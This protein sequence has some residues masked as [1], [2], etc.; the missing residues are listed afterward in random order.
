MNLKSLQI[1][2]T[3]MKKGSLAKAADQHCLSESAASRQISQLEAQV[4]FK[5]FSREKRNL[6]PTPKGYKFY[7]EI[8]RILYGLN[9][10]PDIVK[11]ITL[12]DRN[13]LRVVGIPR[14]VRNIMS[15]AVARMCAEHKDIHVHIDVQAMR[16][17]E[18]WVAGYQFNLGLGRVP[19][20]HPSIV[21]KT[22]CSLPTVAVL[23]YGHP[24]SNRSEI[25]LADLD[26]L[27]LVSL[28]KDTFLAKNIVSLY[29]SQGMVYNP[30]IEVASSFHAC[31]IVASGYGFTIGDPLAAHSLGDNAVSIV[32][33]TTDFKFDFAFFEPVDADLSDS[34]ILFQKYILE[35]TKEF[36]D[37]YGYP[38][39]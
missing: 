1:F 11:D 8:R 34:T 14:L 18:K 16:N 23:P 28:I 27:P 31:S 3:I 39:F 33:L 25:T 12:S 6:K 7:Q 10:I 29:E 30:D 9:E 21:T 20:E 26:G 19:A 17:I 22:I 36:C 15:P 35:V 4:G 13:H 38:S 24:L 32:P 5:L 37:K 2:E